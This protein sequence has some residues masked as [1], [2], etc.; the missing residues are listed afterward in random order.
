MEGALVNE[1][2]RVA[3]QAKVGSFELNAELA[4][5]KEIIALF[6]PSGSGKSSILNCI[7]GLQRI[8]KGEIVVDRKSVV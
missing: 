8:E 6:G 4:G 2:L 5:D 3:I 1:F 7:T